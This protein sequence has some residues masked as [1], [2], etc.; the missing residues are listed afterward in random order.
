M[1][2]LIPSEEIQDKVIELA[3]EINSNEV[4][5]PI[6]KVFVCLLNGG[7]MFFSDL[8]KHIDFDF[9]CDFMRVKSYV[10]KNEQGDINI[11]KDLETPIKGK[12]VYIIDDIYDSGNTMEAVIDY[13]NV[14]QPHSITVVTLLTRSSS[15]FPL[16]PSHVGFILEDEWV[17]GYGM[18]DED[19]FMRNKPDLY[20]I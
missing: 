16:Y 11:S 8:V 12:D 9:E 5:N 18:D 13:L 6:P 1:N 3:S 4:G 2:I 7:F 14:K 20:E 15:Q 17:V 19:G 10:K